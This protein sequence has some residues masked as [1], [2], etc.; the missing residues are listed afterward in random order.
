MASLESLVNPGL[1][2]CRD[3]RHVELGI[4]EQGEF[5]RPA[6]GQHIRPTAPA[7][8]R[9]VLQTSLSAKI[10]KSLERCENAPS[11]F[12]RP[13]TRKTLAHEFPGRTTSLALRFPSVGQST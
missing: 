8:C 6:D 11:C 9:N 13:W 1:S 4:H 7:R 5:E 10:H 3:F 12:A 2:F